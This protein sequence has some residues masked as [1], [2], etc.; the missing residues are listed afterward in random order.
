MVV[1]A[2]G[3]AGF[4]AVALTAAAFAI[5]GGAF[6]NTISAFAAFAAVFAPQLLLLMAYAKGC[7]TRRAFMLWAMKFSL[8]FLLMAVAARGLGALSLLAAPGFVF[9]VVAG[10]G[11]NLYTAAK[12]TMEVAAHNKRRVN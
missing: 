1:V 9:G 11:V 6:A 8:V 5:G 3:A 12:M 7:D 10:V 2:L 4:A